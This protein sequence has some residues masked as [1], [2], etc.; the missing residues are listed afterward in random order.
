MRRSITCALLALSDLVHHDDQA[1]GLVDLVVVLL[2]VVVEG[3]ALGMG[4][5]AG[6]NVGAAGGFSLANGARPAAAAAAVTRCTWRTERSSTVR[7]PGPMAAVPSTITRI[8]STSFSASVAVSFR[9]APERAAG[10]VDAR[11]VDEDH[12]GVGGRVVQDPED[13]VACGVRS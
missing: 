10:A 9:R 3:V 1:G 4:R 5:L 13:P 8:T 2:V 12:L 6:V 11:R 7:S